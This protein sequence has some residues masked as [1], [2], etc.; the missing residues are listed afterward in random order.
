M[1]SSFE[2]ML[3]NR[4]QLAE[5]AQAKINSLGKQSYDSNE[6]DERLW[7]LTH[8]KNEDGMGRATIRFLP[9]PMGEDVNFALYYG[10][11]EKS[12]YN[13]KWYVHN[14]RMSFGE[15]G[16]NDPAYQYNG[17]VYADQ[18][19]TDAQKKKMSMRRQK[20]FITNILVVDDP[21]EPSNNGKVFLFEYGP[22]IHKI[23]EKRIKPDPVVDDYEA[24]FPFDPIEGCNF[25]IKIVSEKIE[26]R[27]TPNYL[28]STWEDVGPIDQDMT[29]V[30]EIWK[31]CY[32][33][34][35]FNDPENTQLFS[36]LARQKADL[37]KWLGEDAPEPEQESKPMK[38][39]T[40]SDSSSFDDD[41]GDLPWNTDEDETTASE[42]DKPSLDESDDDD[43]FFSK[44]D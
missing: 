39:E 17:K 9:A 33:L 29:K 35:P 34:K 36:S 4:K 30:E 44:F 7:S 15:P 2:E 27:L 6:K 21:V 16:E 12:P 38:E 31:K 41:E 43:D 19:L 1:A 26:G 3:K 11:F 14:S 25:K 37:A 23:I 28:Q 5:K 13:N 32:P 22:M 20:K 40:S 24:A 18:S 8:L 42:P 10:Y